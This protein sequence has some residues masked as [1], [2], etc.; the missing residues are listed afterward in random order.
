MLLIALLL[1]CQVLEDIKPKSYGDPN[2]LHEMTENLI[3]LEEGMKNERI[4]ITS[5]EDLSNDI[6]D[7]KDGQL[8][9]LVPLTFPADFVGKEGTKIEE[10]V[11]TKMNKFFNASTTDHTKDIDS[12]EGILEH[13]S[14][15]DFH[16]TALNFIVR[17][18]KW[19]IQ[20]RS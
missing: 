18:C 17:T 10:A 16:N 8:P 5:L 9:A 11:M 20:S 4:P 2:S 14:H 13:I 6:S 19:Q 15:V 7:T 12:S 3:K 1:F